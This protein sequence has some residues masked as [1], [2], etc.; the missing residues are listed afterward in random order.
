MRIIRIAVILM[1]VVCLPLFAHTAEIQMTS[2]TQYLWYQDFLSDDEDQNEIAEYLR[3]NA[4]KLDKDGKISIYGYGRVIHQF[5]DSFEVRPEIANDTFGRMYYLYLDYRD[6]IKDHLDVRAGRTYVSAAAVAGTVDGAY[7]DVKNLGPMGITLFGGRR[8]IFD[9]KSEIGTSGDSLAG[10]SVYLDTIK[11]THVEVSY[12]RKYADTD[13]ATEN[14]G[15]DF[16]TTPHEKVNVY[17][18]MKYDIVS[19]RFNEVLLGAKVAPLKDLILRGEYYYSYATFD[20][21]SFY[22]FFDINNYKEIGIAA[23]YQVNVDYRIYA[24]YAHE[25]FGGDETANL[26]DLG[27]FARPIK[28]LTLDASYEYRQGFTGKLNGFRFHGAYKIYRAMILAGIDYDDFRRE[29]SREG[30]AK[31]YWAGLHY[32]INKRFSAVLR[33]EDNTNFL[34]DDSF[35]GFVALTI[36]L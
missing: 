32:E 25:D 12:G 24:K 16:S 34:F 35:Q 4:T 23:E 28:D 27:F 18:R 21:S 26:Y 14:V 7:L 22:R 20:K 11:F 36:N 5:S 6:A 19:S 2:S 8:V 33:L 10:G 1:A 31:K 13:L 30:T 3:L 15:L 29:D 17:G 9:N